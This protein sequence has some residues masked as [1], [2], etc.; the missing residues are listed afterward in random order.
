MTLKFY[1]SPFHVTEISEVAS[2]YTL[3]TDLIIMIRNLIEQKGWTEQE[4]AEILEVTQTNI[5]DLVNGKIDEFTL[6]M[7]FY[8]LDKLGF[9]TEFI[10]S[11]LEEASIKIH[12]DKTPVIL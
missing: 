2:K 8:M 7:L 9:K 1:E 4:S 6:D 3:K 5:L 12:K 10:S 11:N